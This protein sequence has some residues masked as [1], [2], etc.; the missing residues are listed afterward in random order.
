MSLNASSVRRFNPLTG[1]WV[2]VSSGRQNRPW[3]GQIEP[4]SGHEKPVT[5]DKKCAL[6]PGTRRASGEVNADYNGTYVFDNDFPALAAEVPIDEPI[7]NSPLFNNRYDHGVCRVI[8]F[9]EDHSQTLAKMAT[10]CIVDVVSLWVEQ[11][12]ELF[13][14]PGINHVQIFENRGDAMG[15]SNPHPHGQIWAQGHVPTIPL[16]EV[17][18]MAEYDASHGRSLLS[19]YL[20]EELTRGERVVCENEHFAVVVPY[21]A[22][23]PFE[24]LLIP[25]R[26]VGLLTELSIEERV[27]LADIIRRISVRYDNLFQTSFPYSSG[28]HQRPLSLDPKQPYHLHMH[29]FPP[30]LRSSS[31]RKFMVGYEMMAEAQR[32]LSP[33]EAASHLRNQAE[34]HYLES[35]KSYGDIGSAER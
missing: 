2:L 4:N 23:W 6:C 8:C 12:E 19:D 22:A 17:G 26:C 13:D 16:K 5:F 10:D 34:T 15:C 20:N 3:T 30:L 33:E 35:D 29:Y 14:R 24:T 28:I 11:T 1:D 32:D 7:E 27:A 25:K 9:S 31:V 18:A 21:W